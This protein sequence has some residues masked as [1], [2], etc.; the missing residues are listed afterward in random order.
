[1]PVREDQGMAQQRQRTL[2]NVR[3]V[4]HFWTRSSNAY[5][6]PCAAE[7]RSQSVFFLASNLSHWIFQETLSVEKTGKMFQSADSVFVFCDVMKQVLSERS[8]FTVQSG[9]MGWSQ[10]QMRMG[11]F[12]VVRQFHI[13]APLLWLLLQYVGTK[14]PARDSIAC[15]ALGYCLHLWKALCAFVLGPNAVMLGMHKWVVSR[16]CGNFS[17]QWYCILFCLSWKIRLGLEWSSL[18]DSIPFP[19][20]SFKFTSCAMPYPKSCQDAKKKNGLSNVPGVRERDQ[21]MRSSSLKC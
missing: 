3:I 7:L 12:Y 8:I 2:Q 9:R 5:L 11:F 14:L 13:S 17:E 18:R 15:D 21:T 16:D 10:Q 6:L 4:R 20:V 19:N 1:M